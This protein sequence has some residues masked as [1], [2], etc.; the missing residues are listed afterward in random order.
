L[1]L[2]KLK[3]DREV[4]SKVIRQSWSTG[5]GCWCCC[6]H[7]HD[8]GPGWIQGEHIGKS[9]LEELTNRGLPSAT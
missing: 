6:D 2:V 3:K 7:G 5:E 9:K 1:V 8:P 4:S